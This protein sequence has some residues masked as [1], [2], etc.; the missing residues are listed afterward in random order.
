VN[1]EHLK[2][3]TLN[4]PLVGNVHFLNEKIA[5]TIPLPSS[6]FSIFIIGLQHGRRC[7][8]SLTLF[9]I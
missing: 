5:K 9:R 3:N 4:K 1:Q 6:E 8:S 2:Y 7:F